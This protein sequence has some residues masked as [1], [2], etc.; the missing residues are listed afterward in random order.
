MVSPFGPTKTS[1]QAGPGMVVLGRI[2]GVFGVK[3]WVKVY[4][5]T[6]PLE[7]ILGYS[8]WLLREASGWREYRLAE[9]KRHG[10]G[11][12]ARL[13]GFEDRDQ[14][15]RGTGCRRWTTATTTGPIWK[16][17]GCRPRKAWTWAR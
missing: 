14:A 3:G 15:S 2:A 4:S 8:P 6:D 5:H 11:L 17:C 1:A 16:G 7:N 12:V 10:K 13:E 9:G